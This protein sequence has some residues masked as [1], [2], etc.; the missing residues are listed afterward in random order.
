[1]ASTGENTARTPASLLAGIRAGDEGAWHR[2]VDLYG[3]LV[4]YW[5]RRAGLA[6]EDVADVAQEVFRSVASGIGTFRKS[7]PSNSFRG[8]LNVVTHNRICDYF[9]AR[10]AQV[11]AT[12]GS[13][14][15]RA[16]S[17][18]PCD[19]DSD[20]GSA[21]APAAHALVRAALK[22]IRGDFEDRTWQAFCQGVLDGRTAAQIGADLGMSPGAVR[23]AK[24]RVLQRLREELG[25]RE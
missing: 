22:R 15:Q 24:A 9:R 16:L 4:Y 2:L 19:A 18:V 10:A 6:P 3:P 21:D 13:D 11:D 25:E 20:S 23:K 14:A 1:M 12:G 7:K 17:Q 5:C 8:W